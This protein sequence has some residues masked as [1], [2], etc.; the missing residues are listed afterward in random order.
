MESATKFEGRDG[1]GGEERGLVQLAPSARKSRTLTRTR[2]NKPWRR[3]LHSAGQAFR[4]EVVPVGLCGCRRYANDGLGRLQPVTVSGPVKPTMPSFLFH[5][6]KK[7]PLH[8]HLLAIRQIGDSDWRMGRPVQ[9]PQ[10]AP[11]RRRFADG[12][13]GG[14]L[15]LFILF[16]G[17]F[18]RSFFNIFIRKKSPGRED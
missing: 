9:R 8:M 7:H 5:L 12:D 13:H 6:E 17:F 2:R 15:N 18:C 1:G 10:G 11:R 4:G 16:M 3:E 14:L